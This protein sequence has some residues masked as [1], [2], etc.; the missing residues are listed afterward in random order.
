MTTPERCIEIIS[1]PENGS[2]SEQVILGVLSEESIDK[3]H[4]ELFTG[5]PTTSIFANDN[6]IIKLRLEYDTHHYNALKF[7]ATALERE[8]KI[9]FYHPDKTWFLLKDDPEKPII[10]N[11]TP[12]LIP[13]HSDDFTTHHKHE[14]LLS[15][16]FTILD[17][18]MEIGVNYDKCLD[19][20]LSNFG[21]DSDNVV[22]YLDDDSYDW[23]SF[24]SFCQFLGIFVRSQA[25]LTP[26]HSFELGHMIRDGII[27]HFKDPNWCTVISEHLKGIFIPDAKKDIVKSLTEGLHSGNTFSYKPQTSGD[28]I[29]LLADIHSNAP[30]LEA[31]LSYLESRDIDH[32]IMLGDV[33]GYGPHPSQCIEMI[34]GL[35]WLSTIRGNHDNAIAISHAVSGMNQMAA[36]SVK[37]TAEQLSQEEKD[38][39]GKL[40]PYI[41]DKHWL[42]VHGAPKDRT[43]FNA[44]VYKQTFSE[45][46]DE[47]QSRD[48]R[49]CFHGHSHIPTV[50]Y[51]DTLGDKECREEKQSIDSYLH[52]LICPGSVGQPRNQTVGANMALIDLNNMEFEFIRI[53]YNL[54]TTVEDMQKHNFPSQLIKR[55]LKGQ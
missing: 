49:W 7:S 28:V 33:V 48:I 18:Y 11:I 15:F 14:D 1:H 13:L 55:L 39:L 6:Y 50:F 27:K 45:N 8:K 30:A 23:D 36:W 5:R 31:A 17:R 43:F 44:Y 35:D 2:I 20:G 21:I 53:P 38:W 26:V 46:L 40:E 32:G 25:W 3:E 52:A 10:A 54:R 51:R 16:L 34:Q 9:A 4:G 19:L 37:W 24:L 41:Q 47:I 22:Y 42:A 29:A 12:R